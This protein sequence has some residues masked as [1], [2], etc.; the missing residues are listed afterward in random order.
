MKYVWLS[1][2][3]MGGLLAAGKQD[4]E[5]NVNNRYTVETVVVSGD[6]WSTSPAVDRDHKISSGL[7]KEIAALVGEKLNP[8]RLDDLAKRLRKELRAR[9]VEHH[10]LR[11]KSPEYVRVVFQVEVPPT[12]FDASVPKFLYQG[13]Q[14]W[15]GAVEGTATVNNNGFT[16]GLVSDG[17]E[18]VERYTGVVARYESQPVLDQRA[19]L[20]FEYATYHELWN[21]STVTS[22]NASQLYR[23][24]DEFQPVLSVR[25][26][27]PL[28]VS[29]GAS[30]ESLGAQAPGAQPLAANA[31]VAGARY[32]QEIEGTM[33]QAV[34]ANYDLRAGSRALASDYAYSR[35][36]WGFR[37]RITHGKHELVD[38]GWGGMILGTAPLFERFVLGN[39]TSLRGWNKFDVDPLGGNRVV[40]NS[41]EYHYGVFQV[42]CDQGA[43]WDSGQ[44][45]VAR[46]SVGAGL[47]QGIF[48]VALAFPLRDGRMD[49]V[50]MVGMNY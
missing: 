19:R 2:L 11:G 31:F 20:L 24:R 22:A 36:R 15:S 29:F 26:A 42:F 39:S 12:R 47:R 7:R 28:E 41:V 48:S 34:E 43:V 8:E 1:L 14:G 46:T 5:T 35:H 10:V 37:Y 16:A 18:L 4:S 13:E 3:L 21:P 33:D 30:F 40:H 23:T 32:H 6:G 49:P 27:R 9:T 44:A 38:D 45:A 17:D 25:V 50:F